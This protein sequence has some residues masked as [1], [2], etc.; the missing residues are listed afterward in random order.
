MVNTVAFANTIAAGTGVTLQG[1][2]SVSASSARRFLLELTDVTSGS[3]AVT[4][5]GL[6]EGSA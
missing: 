5:T 6:M 4:L 1:N 2:T 3:E